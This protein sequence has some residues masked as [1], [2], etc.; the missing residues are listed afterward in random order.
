MEGAQSKDPPV[1]DSFDNLTVTL[2]HVPRL[3]CTPLYS[4]GVNNLN[5]GK[6][7]YY[8]KKLKHEI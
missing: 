1:E 4:M 3:I 8:W 6:I 7:R 2:L 5:Q